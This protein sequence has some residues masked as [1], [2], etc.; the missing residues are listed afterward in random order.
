MQADCSILDTSADCFA[1]RTVTQHSGL[2]WQRIKEQA[3]RYSV[4]P[5]QRGHCC[6]IS[7]TLPPCSALSPQLLCAREETHQLV[8]SRME[9]AVLESRQYY[10]SVDNMTQCFCDTAISSSILI[11]TL[12]T[13]HL[14]VDLKCQLKS[15]C[16][17]SKIWVCTCSITKNLCNKYRYLSLHWYGIRSDY[18]LS[19]VGHTASI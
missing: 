11:C 9:R 13:K 15:L 18:C 1:T 6:R 3:G 4:S 17:H 19:Y 5:G 7:A 10:N 12:S 14:L 16:S 8:S 2:S